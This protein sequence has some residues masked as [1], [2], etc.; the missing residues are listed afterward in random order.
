MFGGGRLS[1]FANNIS[2]YDPY[3]GNVVLLMGFENNLTDAST[4]SQTVTATNTISYSTSTAKF[5]TYSINLPSSS[6]LN[7][8]NTSSFYFGT[9]DFTIETWVYVP[10]G[11]SWLTGNV[12]VMDISQKANGVQGGPSFFGLNTS[13]NLT[14]NSYR[15][16]FYD[17]TGIGFI[18]TN[19]VLGSNV[20]NHICA[21]RVGG[22]AYLGANGVLKNCGTTTKNWFP[23]GVKIK[24]DYYLENG[25]NANFDEFRVTRGVWRYGTGTNYT[26]PSERF[27]RQ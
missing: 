20:W 24:Q 7:I 14:V 26:V 5:D 22:N 2:L 21:G 1:L 23:Y 19:N 27:P 6:Y 3:W 11:G 13:S 17:N 18:T 15:A 25:Y 12:C 10:S 9:G 8:T 4:S 16:A